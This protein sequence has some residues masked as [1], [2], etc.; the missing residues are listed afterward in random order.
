MHQSVTTLWSYWVWKLADPVSLKV[1][2]QVGN[3]GQ[4]IWDVYDE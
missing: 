2:L 3:S 1:F 4:E